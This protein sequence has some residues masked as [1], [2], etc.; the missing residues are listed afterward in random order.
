M[1]E[2]ILKKKK[3][4]KKRSVLWIKVINQALNKEGKQGVL[5][6]VLR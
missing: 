4:K 3:K 2:M 1:Q 6:H 5:F